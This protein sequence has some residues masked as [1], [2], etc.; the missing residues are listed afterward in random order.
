[1]GMMLKIKDETSTG[2]F[3][4]ERLVEFSIECITVKT[5]IETR[6]TQEVVS[7][8]AET[9]GQFFGLVQ[10]TESEKMLNGFRLKQGALVDIEKQKQAA[11][12]AFKS[13]A[14]FLLINDKQVTELEDEIIITPS[15]VVVFLKLIPLVG[16]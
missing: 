7:Y 13:N 1:M 3:I 11:I 5:L 4:S 8:N 2:K 10:P 9:G 12:R 15:T 16:G 6:V 14:F